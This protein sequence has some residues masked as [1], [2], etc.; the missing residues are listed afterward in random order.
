M[1]S[2]LL[3]PLLSLTRSGLVLR[4]LEEVA[5]LVLSTR[6]RHLPTTGK[7][8]H[9][10]FNGS[11]CHHKVCNGIQRIFLS[12]PHSTLH[13]FTPNAPAPHT[14]PELLRYTPN[15]PAPHTAPELLLGP[16]QPRETTAMHSCTLRDAVLEA[17]LEFSLQAPTNLCWWGFGF[18]VSGFRFRQ[19][20][21]LCW[22]YT[23]LAFG[24]DQG[25]EVYEADSGVTL[26]SQRCIVQRRKVACNGAAVRGWGLG[27]AGWGLGVGG[28]GL[29]VG[30]WLG[31]GGRGSGFEVMYPTPEAPDSKAQHR[32]S[33]G[34]K[35]KAYT[36]VRDCV[37]VGSHFDQ[38]VACARP[39]S[40]R[41]E[42]KERIKISKEP[43][44][45]IQKKPTNDAHR[46]Q[47]HTRSY[48]SDV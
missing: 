44:R 18:R 37:Y 25:T 7:C 38:T 12:P 8:H 45:R 24:L 39:V 13:L 26:P 40:K 21:N 41:Q 1:S 5:H 32:K 4:I 30:G 48:S 46:R 17:L 6:P 22:C 11:H 33:Q 28:W 35:P 29:G 10:A 31:V 2:P 15:A 3:S 14:A 36:W 9:K 20:E 19:I 42:K 27:V 47:C 34:L 16:L 23:P 43:S